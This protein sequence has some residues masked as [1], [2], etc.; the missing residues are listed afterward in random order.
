MSVEL[1]RLKRFEGGEGAFVAFIRPDEPI[2]VGKIVDINS[3][4]LGV[5][6]LAAEEF[7]EGPSMVEIFGPSSIRIDRIKSTVV[8]DREI[9]EESSSSLSVRRCGIRF[10]Q[11][12]RSAELLKFISSTCPGSIAGHQLRNGILRNKVS[13]VEIG[14]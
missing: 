9:S 10:D 7:G 2:I 1:R 14:G 13:C 12:C 5:R 4:G 8:Y 3:G 6:Y 11:R